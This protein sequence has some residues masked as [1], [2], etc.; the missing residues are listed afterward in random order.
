MVIEYFLLEI[1]F[2]YFLSLIC[3]TRLHLV[4]GSVCVFAL[5]LDQVWIDWDKQNDADKERE[6]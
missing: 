4:H 1:Y 2:S 6:C 3:G 5:Y